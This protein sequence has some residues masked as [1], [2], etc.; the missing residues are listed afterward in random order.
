MLIGLWSVVH[1]CERVEIKQ[2]STYVLLSVELCLMEEQRRT[3]GGEGR[4]LYRC[5][6]RE[7]YKR[8]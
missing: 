7:E 1:A 8:K 6:R 3:D 5:M 4:Q 2:C